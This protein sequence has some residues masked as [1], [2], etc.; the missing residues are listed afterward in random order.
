MRKIVF[1]ILPAFILLTNLI[2]PNETSLIDLVENKVSEEFIIEVPILQVIFE[3]FVGLVKYY[4]LMYR[5]QSDFLSLF[6]YLFLFLLLFH[7]K[8]NIKSLIKSAIFTLSVILLTVFSFNHYLQTKIVSKNRDIII[9]DFHSHTYYSHDSIASP[10]KNIIAH[11][12]AGYN[13]LAITDHNEYKGVIKTQ[14]ILPFF[15]NKIR[16]IPAQEVTMNDGT[17]ILVYGAGA[18]KKYNHPSIEYLRL[19]NAILISEDASFEK[20]NMIDGFEIY[21]QSKKCLNYGNI[22][23]MLN[24]CYSKELILLAGTNFHGY[25]FLQVYTLIPSISVNLTNNELINLLKKERK[26]I[27]TAILHDLTFNRKISPILFPIC[28]FAQLNLNGVLSWW[29]WSCIVILIPKKIKKIFSKVI[30]ISITILIF[31]S[32][33]DFLEIPNMFGRALTLFSLSLSFLLILIFISF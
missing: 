20:V 19:E 30:E 14:R 9:A 10:I 5:S 1:F 12:N 8:I 28:Y 25:G 23:K 16:I 17:H 22:G 18:M 15:K 7:L 31:L 21:S 6:M 24:Y 26:K 11:I 29:L 4:C 27:K 3:P 2:I 13:L 33:I 32:F